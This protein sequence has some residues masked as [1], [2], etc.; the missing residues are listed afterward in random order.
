[1]DN[2]QLFNEQFGGQ[3]SSSEKKD[4]FKLLSII[5]S[6]AGLLMVFLGTIFTCTCSAKKTFDTDSDGKHS[7]SLV[8]IVT[9]I[10]VIIAVAGLVFG[11]MEMKKKSDKLVLASVVIAA[12]SVVFGLVPL[13]TICGYNCSLNNASEKMVEKGM[14]D[15]DLSDLSD[16]FN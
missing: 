6:G 5:F 9:I 14:Q 10:G 7:M 2:N 8:C 15:L 4:I 3:Q 16:M 1:M 11:L 12:F 13:F